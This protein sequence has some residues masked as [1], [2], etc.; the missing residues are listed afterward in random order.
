MASGILRASGKYATSAAVQNNAIS[1]LSDPLLPNKESKFTDS[2]S[3]LDHES[4]EDEDTTLQSGD[5]VPRMS[6]KDIASTLAVSLMVTG[7]LAASASAMLAVPSVVVFLMGGVC[8]VNAPTVASKQ[9]SISKSDGIRTSV[10]CIRKEIKVLKDEVEFLSSSVDDLKEESDVLIGLEQDLRRIATDQGKNVNELVDLVN[11]N[12]LVLDQMKG[13]LRQTF[14][15]A[16]ARVVMRSDKDGDMK[17]DA[18]EVPLLSLRL[19]IQ[20]EPYGIKLDANKFDNMIREDNDISHVLKFC[21]NLLFEGESND[22][23]DDN[24]VDS[25]L[26]F[27][28]ESFCKSLDDEPEEVSLKMTYDEKVTMITV[29]DKLCK[30][31]VENA[32]GKTMTLMPNN[33]KKDMRKKTIVEEVKRRQTTLV[34]SRSEPAAKLS[35]FNLSGRSESVEAI[36]L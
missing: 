35:K 34:T 25:A 28:F 4:W 24:S 26:T 32:R 11:E 18:S 27:D 17:I 9:W 13:N 29:D 36:S 14:V 31:S 16:M 21:G 7:G 10:N 20:L 22:N 15:A 33:N 12:E 6:G 23:D 1:A 8:I 3:S 2:L 5:F 30:G 19:Q